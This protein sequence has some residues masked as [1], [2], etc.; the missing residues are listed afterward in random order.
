VRIF[1]LPLAFMLFFVPV[2]LHAQRITAILL[3]QELT[4]GKGLKTR[5]LFAKFA[6]MLLVQVG[7]SALG[8]VPGIDTHYTQRSLKNSGN[9]D[10]DS[11]ASLQ[12]TLLPSCTIPVVSVALSGVYQTALI[13]YAVWI[14]WK[15]R[16]L[17][18]IFNNSKSILSYFFFFWLCVSVLPVQFLLDVQQDNEETVMLMRVTA[19][20]LMPLMCATALFL[21]KLRIICQ[22]KQNDE[23]SLVYLTRGS[24]QQSNSNTSGVRISQISRQR[25]SASGQR[26]TLPSAAWAK[27]LSGLQENLAK[28]NRLSLSARAGSPALPLPPPPS[29]ARAASSSSINNSSSV[30]PPAVTA[31]SSGAAFMPP[32]L[33]GTVN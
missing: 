31:A 14:A 19:I 6:V 33:P 9:S 8:L 11:D 30:A 13:L 4:K 2:L 29:A 20:L 1:A 3:R 17:P 12:D 28:A 26:A 22:G 15:S 27:G 7:L 16:N 18:G 25:G 23:V 32:P 10:A 5:Y 24:S 21:P